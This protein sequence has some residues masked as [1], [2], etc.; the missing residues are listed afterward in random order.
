MKTE[1]KY[2]RERE[3]EAMKKEQEAGQ[4]NPICNINIFYRKSVTIRRKCLRLW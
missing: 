2:N 3:M 4:T 1:V